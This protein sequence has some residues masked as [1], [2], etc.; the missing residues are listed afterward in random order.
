MC[1]TSNGTELTLKYV[2]TDLVIPEKDRGFTEV[3]SRVFELRKKNCS[4][5]SILRMLKS[6]TAVEVS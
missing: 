5:G 3:T 2:A 4:G 1:D 6:A